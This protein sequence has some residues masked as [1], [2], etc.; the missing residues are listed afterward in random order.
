MNFYFSSLFPN[1]LESEFIGTVPNGCV[2]LSQLNDRTHIS[3][4]IQKNKT[5]KYKVKLFI[6][7]GAYTSWTKGVQ[8]DIDEQISYLNSISDDVECYASLDVIPG[9]SGSA[10]L[11]T[12][13]ESEQASKSSWEN[14]LYMRKRVK[15]PDKLIYTFHI[16]ENYE[17]LK[18][19]LSVKSPSFCL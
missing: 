3:N 9:T 10:R 12:E 8:I 7:S 2:L 1:T 5:S 6:D 11:P 15:H 17:Y 18:K 16:G 4:W 19:A 14:F 13:Q